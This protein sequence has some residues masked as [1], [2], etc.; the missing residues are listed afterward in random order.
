MTKKIM[1]KRINI[2]Y[3]FVIFISFVFIMRLININIKNHNYYIDKLNSSF[4]YEYGEEM[5]RGNIYDKNGKLLVGNKAVN[6]LVFKGNISEKEKIALASLITMKIDIKLPSYNEDYIKEYLVSLNREKLES[7]ID[8]SI[9]TKYKNREITYEEYNKELMRVIDKDDILNTSFKTAYIY[10]LM[11]NGYHYNEKVIKDKLTN[12]EYIFINELNNEYLYTI[13]K[14]KRYYPY[15]NTLRGVFGSVSS[16]PSEKLNDYIKNG[17]LINDTVGVS[18]LESYY[19]EYLRGVREVYYND[20]SGNKVIV[21]NARNGY[22]LYLTIDIDKQRKVDNIIKKELVKAKKEPNTDYL[23]K[24][25]VLITNPNDGSIIVSSGIKLVPKK[26]KY[27]FIDYSEYIWLDAVTP[28]SIVK[29]ASHM[30]GYTTGNLKP[31]FTVRDSCIKIMNTPKKCSWTSLG[32]INDI[33]ALKYSSNYYQ[34]LTAIKVGKGNYYYNGPLSL[35]KNAFKTYRKMYNNFGLGVKT[36]V[37]LPYESVGFKGNDE[38]T[39]SILDFSIGQYDTY[40]IGNLSSYINTISLSGKRYSLH[41]LDYIKDSDGNII[42]KYEKNMINKVKAKKVYWKRI[43]EG[44]KEVLKPYGTGYYF[45]DPKLKPAGKTGTSE[46]FLD[47]NH[48]GMID[49]PTITHTFASYFPYNKPKT[50]I[51]VVTPDVGIGDKKYIS[52]VNKQISYKVS[53]IFFEK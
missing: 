20:A 45:V 18:N 10:H 43:K 8:K 3:Y 35:N 22:D 7:I 34:F 5:P 30:V 16:I 50:S 36:G 42:Y 48:D 25:Y 51:V 28:G 47:T 11:N 44:F 26:D 14:Y 41:Y 31:G 53:R 49:T 17:Y 24:N 29:G 13:V 15:G 12:E 33:T 2:I 23:S 4:I 38:Y 37:D 1:I 32:V 46:S 27:S 52:Y 40:T 6:T 39:Y 21:K 19:E 9:I